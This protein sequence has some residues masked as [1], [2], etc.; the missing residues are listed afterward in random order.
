MHVD[1]IPQALLTGFEKEAKTIGAKDDAIAEGLQE[2]RAAFERGMQGLRTHNAAA[3][4]R[5]LK[6]AV[7]EARCA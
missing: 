1:T 6:A 2:I 5:H 3:L 4:G 7:K